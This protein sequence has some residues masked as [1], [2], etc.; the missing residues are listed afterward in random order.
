MID[1]RPLTTATHN[2]CRGCLLDELEAVDDD[3]R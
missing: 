3:N 1:G 2:L